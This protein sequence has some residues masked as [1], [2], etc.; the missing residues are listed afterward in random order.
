M[1]LCNYVERI[2]DEGKGL[3]AEAQQH[4]KQCSACAQFL[5]EWRLV[6]AG[7]RE[8]AKEMPPEASI[9]FTARLMRR[10]EDGQRAVPNELGFFEQVGRRFVYATLVLAFMLLLALAL[11]S[12]GPLRAP[13]SGSGSAEIMLEQPEMAVMQSEPIIGVDG[14]DVI[15]ADSLVGGNAPRG[16]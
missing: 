5:C 13:T 6:S 2:L 12:T 10:I 8:L 7:F 4:A 1:M 11:P 14:S 15:P 16:K 9:G 3:T